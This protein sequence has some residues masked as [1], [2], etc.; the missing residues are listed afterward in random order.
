MP[1][2]ELLRGDR[3]HSKNGPRSRALGLRDPVAGIG[4][5]RRRGRRRRWPDLDVADHVVAGQQVAAGRH[6]RQ[7]GMVEAHAGVEHGDDDRSRRR[8]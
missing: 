2:H 8:S 5:H 7:I 4:S 6:R 1:C 3:M